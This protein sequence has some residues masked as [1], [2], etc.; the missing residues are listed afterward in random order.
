MEKN[1]YLRLEPNPSTE[2][3]ATLALAYEQHLRNKMAYLTMANR[4]WYDGDKE[5]DEYFGE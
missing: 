5:L 1:P 3:Y 2:A 4:S